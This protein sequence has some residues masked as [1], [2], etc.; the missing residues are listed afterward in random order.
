MDF[1]YHERTNTTLGE[2][3]NDSKKNTLIRHYFQY[4]FGMHQQRIQYK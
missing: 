3:E 1:Y 2:D 4:K